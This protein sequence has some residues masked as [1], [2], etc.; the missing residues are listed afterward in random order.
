MEAL[1]SES[2]KTNNED[3]VKKTISEVRSKRKSKYE[4]ENINLR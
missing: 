1:V 4:N 2:E 3:G